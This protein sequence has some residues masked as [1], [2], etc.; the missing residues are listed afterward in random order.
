MSQSVLSPRIMRHSYAIKLTH[1][2]AII[3]THVMELH[4]QPRAKSCCGH[5][6]EPSSVSTE[7]ELQ[8]QTHVGHGTQASIK[9]RGMTAIMIISLIHCLLSLIKRQPFQNISFLFL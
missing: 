8:A 3:N 9:D 4:A 7:L 6:S 1:S 5:E 2:G